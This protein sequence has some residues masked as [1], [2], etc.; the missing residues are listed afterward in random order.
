M[1]TDIIADFKSLL[2]E[3]SRTSGV[4]VALFLVAEQFGYDYLMAVDAR[5][6][7]RRL[8][9][10]LI[11][12]AGGNL[13]TLEFDRVRPFVDHPIYRRALV[14]DRPFRVDDLREELGIDVDRWEA[15][16]PPPSRGTVGVALPIHRD[17]ELEVFVGFRGRKP[18][19]SDFALAF[20]HACAHIAFDRMR[21]LASGA[22][23]P[24]GA[25]S[26]RE[27]ECMHWVAQ[28]KTDAE[29]AAI[30]GIAERTV[31]FHVTNAKRRLNVGSRAEAVAQRT[32]SKDQS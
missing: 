28:G 1:L 9:P 5:R 22:P 16:R 21:E 13:E 23:E 3:S 27:A 15:M 11:F 26:K 32:V 17:G 7:S 8:T 31:R 6:L 29:I 18:D 25:L 10:A 19:V 12:D 2:S 20:L 30:V 14:V 4:G 24:H